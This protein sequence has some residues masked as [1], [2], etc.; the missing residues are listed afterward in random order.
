M[1]GLSNVRNYSAFSVLNRDQ[2]T[3]GHYLQDAGYE[4]LVAGKWQLF[5]AEHYK[6]RFRGKGTLPENAGFDHHCLWQVRRLGKRYW[7]PQLTIDGVDRQF[8]EDKFGPDVATRY[9]TD[10]ME[11]RDKSKPF[12]IYYPMILGHSPFVSPPGAKELGNSKKKQN[13]SVRANG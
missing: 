6:E 11:S 4:T 1:T 13:R 5:G 12:F 7:K 3:I 10:F 8:G 9:I 2:R